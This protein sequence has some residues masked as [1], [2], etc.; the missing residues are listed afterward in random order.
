[1]INQIK[2]NIR[3]RDILRLIRVEDYGMFIQL[4]IGFLLAVL[5]W[6][7]TQNGKFHLLIA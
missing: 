1:M 3:L 7:I 4:I 2:S 5:V 6:Q